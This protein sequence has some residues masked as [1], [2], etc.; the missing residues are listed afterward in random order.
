MHPSHLGSDRR[1]RDRLRGLYGEIGLQYPPDGVVQVPAG[2]PADHRAPDVV[3]G[4]AP[5]DYTASRQADPRI[6]AVRRTREDEL[7]EVGGAG[8]VLVALRV[9]MQ[10]CRFGVEV[11]PHSPDT[12]AVAHPADSEGS[13]EAASVERVKTPA[14][15]VHG[16]EEGEHRRGGQ[17][18]DPFVVTSRPF[19]RRGET[20]GVREQ[21]A[22]R[23]SSAAAM[24]SSAAAT[25]MFAVL[26]RV[27]GLAFV[28]SSQ[29][30]CTFFVIAGRCRAQ[31][32]PRP[33][34]PKPT[35]RRR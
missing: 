19:G 25:T 13:R 4:H 35:R 1:A 28:H 3:A 20:I 12:S 7:R 10:R 21:V 14:D 18:I 6:G 32:L 31:R 22:S 16:G 29:T 9:R 15:L 8:R 11:V 17:R 30:F 34:R 33:T 5:R 26:L 2:H 24:R 27:F 23:S